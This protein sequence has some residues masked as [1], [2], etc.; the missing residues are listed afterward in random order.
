MFKGEYIAIREFRKHLSWIFKGV[1][2]IAKVR[3][4]FFLI[5]NTDDALDIIDSI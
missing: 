2:D 5:Q 4:K 1:R 3:K